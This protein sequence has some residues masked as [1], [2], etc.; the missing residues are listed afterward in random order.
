MSTTTPEEKRFATLAARYALAGHA[1]IRSNPQD[2]HVSFYCT[3]WGFIKPL[4]NLDAAER[5]LSQIGGAR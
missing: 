2:G 5:F 1:L 3:Q 4:A